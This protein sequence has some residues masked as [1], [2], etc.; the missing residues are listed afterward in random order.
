MQKSV[1]NIK[2]DLCWCWKAKNFCAYCQNLWCFI[3]CR[4]TNIAQNFYRAFCARWG[5][6]NYSFMELHWVCSIILGKN[7]ESNLLSRKLWESMFTVDMVIFYCTNKQEKYNEIWPA[8]TLWNE[9]ILMYF[10]CNVFFIY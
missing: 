9:C 1:F 4:V 2:D 10:N 6:I 5:K 7:C 8:I 3:F